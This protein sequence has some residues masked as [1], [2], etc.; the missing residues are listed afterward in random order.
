MTEPV[1]T[2]QNQQTKSSVLTEQQVHEIISAK[3]QRALI[4][5]EK[6]KNSIQ[7]HDDDEC[8]CC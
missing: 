5:Y 7:I 8:A 4:Y 1:S 2:K 3:F 6:Y